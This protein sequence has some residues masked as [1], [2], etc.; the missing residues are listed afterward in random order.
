MNGSYI[1]VRLPD[2]LPTGNLSLT[3]TLRGMTSEAKILQIAP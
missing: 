1:I 2:L 3:V